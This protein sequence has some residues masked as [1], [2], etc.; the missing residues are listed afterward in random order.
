MVKIHGNYSPPC[1]YILHKVLKCSSEAE[2]HLNRASFEICIPKLSRKRASQV[3]DK[4]SVF[5]NKAPRTQ[6]SMPSAL[7]SSNSLCH[8]KGL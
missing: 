8:I 5:P 1:G 2:F 7:C 6:N 4:T 3:L